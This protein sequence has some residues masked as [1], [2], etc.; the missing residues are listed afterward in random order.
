L[1]SIF[2]WGIPECIL[3]WFLSGVAEVNKRLP[4]ML[5]TGDSMEKER[6]PDSRDQRRENETSA[7]IDVIGHIPAEL[8][9]VASV[10]SEQ[11]CAAPSV[12]SSYAVWEKE[13]QESSTSSV[14]AAAARK[15][16][17]GNEVEDSASAAGSDWL[18]QRRKKHPVCSSSTNIEKNNLQRV[19]YRIL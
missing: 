17:E 8:L 5:G 9:V 6:G 14:E 3:K 19:L 2:G 1:A 18:H 12:S 4:S 13:R 10:R 7:A 11:S 16:K 15:V